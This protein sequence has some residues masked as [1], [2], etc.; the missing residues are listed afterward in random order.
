MS[1]CPKGSPRRNLMHTT[2]PFLK[3][4]ALSH[5]TCLLLDDLQ[6]AFFDLRHDLFNDGFVLFQFL[7]DRVPAL[8]R[9]LII[10]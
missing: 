10:A 7:L 5:G 4:S 8:F 6:L 2:E 3:S 9:Y 1:Y